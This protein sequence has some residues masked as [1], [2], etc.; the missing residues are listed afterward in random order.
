MNDRYTH[1][2]VVWFFVI[3]FITG[4]IFMYAPIE[5]RL[6]QEIEW[7]DTPDDS[8]AEGGDYLVKVGWDEE[9]ILENR[10]SNTLFTSEIVTQHNWAYADHLPLGSIRDIIDPP[11]QA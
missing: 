7:A 3:S 10:H 2:A 11:D 8:S 5:S 6:N 4:N 9:K 1:I